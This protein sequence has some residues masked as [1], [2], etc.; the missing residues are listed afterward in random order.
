M[1]VSVAMSASSEQQHSQQHEEGG[2]RAQQRAEVIPLHVQPRV[3]RLFRQAVRRGA[4]HQEVEG[5][6][7]RI[8]IGGAVAVE[9]SPCLATAVQL[10][11]SPASTL[12]Q[13]VERT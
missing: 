6:Q 5:M 4:I 3:E 10:L 12:T 9:V 11:D 8:R 2:Q 7:G 1:R 13:L